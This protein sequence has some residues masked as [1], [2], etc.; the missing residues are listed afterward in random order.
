MWKCYGGF[1]LY[2]TYAMQYLSD[3][4]SLN[5][6]DRF[7]LKQCYHCQQIGHVSS[8]CP[9]KDKSPVCFYCMGAHQSKTCLKKRSRTDQCCAKCYNSSISVE[10]ADYQS[11]NAA[12]PLCPVWTREVTRITNNTDI[13]RNVT[14][15]AN[16][17][18]NYLSILVFL[19]LDP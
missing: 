13:Q 17:L 7:F 8:N 19:M 16:K 5:V 10:K 18:T 14:K 1:P 2:R 15:G 4:F 9:S 11:H 6:E 3:D 12:D